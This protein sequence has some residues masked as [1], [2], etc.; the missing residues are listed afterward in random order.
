MTRML[1]ME[2]IYERLSQTGR[3]IDNRLPV[4]ALCSRLI[5]RVERS[6]EV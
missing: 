6:D 2:L 3:A 5:S 1:K 4:E